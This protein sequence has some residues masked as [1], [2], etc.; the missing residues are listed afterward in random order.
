MLLSPA[1]QN[2]YKVLRLE[3]RAIKVHTSYM[4]NEMS[5]EAVVPHLVERRLLSSA[6]AEEV[7]E[8]N[9]PTR[10]VVKKLYTDLRIGALATFCAA[11][12]CADH[13][14]IAKAISDSE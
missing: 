7:F 10:K 5:A 1:M 3:G 13:S 9:S 8:A 4:I 2:E 6:E 14:H 12:I 11:L